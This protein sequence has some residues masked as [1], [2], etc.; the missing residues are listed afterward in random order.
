ME[1]YLHTPDRTPIRFDFVIANFGTGSAYNVGF[2][3]HADDE[4]FEAHHVIMR[5]R[6]TTDTPFSIIEPGGRITSVFG[7]G[8]EL[9]GGDN[10]ALKPFKVT[11]TYEWQPF[12]SRRRRGET[13]EFDLDVRPHWWRMSQVTKNEIAEVLKKE[14]PRIARAER[15]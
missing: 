1:C 14:L 10:T 15:V 8:P 6:G 9:L 4:D 7:S 13:R 2:T 12:W 11:V 5:G 3:V